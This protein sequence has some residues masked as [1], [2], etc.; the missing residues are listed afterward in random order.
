MFV[1]GGLLAAGP[2]QPQRTRGR[3]QRLLAV[4]RVPPSGVRQQL[5][6]PPHARILRV[7][8]EPIG[9]RVQVADNA[10]G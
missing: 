1:L 10:A 4:D 6:E 7:V 3:Q 2:M 8:A 9:Q 5:T